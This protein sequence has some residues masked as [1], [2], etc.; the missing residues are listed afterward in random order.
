MQTHP[1]VV[2]T[3]LIYIPHVPP[4]VVNGKFAELSPI[5]VILTLDYKATGKGIIHDPTVFT[6]LGPI[7]G[8]IIVLVL[9]I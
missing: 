3:P 9:V 6:K 7:V 8:V 4:V 1:T 2:L 5:I